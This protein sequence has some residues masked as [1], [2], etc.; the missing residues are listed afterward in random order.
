MPDFAAD[1]PFAIAKPEIAESI[2]KPA[3]AEIVFVTKRIPS[4]IT[5]RT[6]SNTCP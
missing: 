1:I 2:G 3:S 6:A 5:M 4:T